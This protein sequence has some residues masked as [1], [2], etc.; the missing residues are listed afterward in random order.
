MQTTVDGFII[1]LTVAAM[2]VVCAVGLAVLVKMACDVIGDATEE[3]KR[4]GDNV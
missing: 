2:V 3:R 1:T 4:K